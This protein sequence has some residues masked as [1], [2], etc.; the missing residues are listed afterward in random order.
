MVKAVAIELRR[1]RPFA[2]CPSH[3]GTTGDQMQRFKSSSESPKEGFFWGVL[4]GITTCLGKGS[5]RQLGQVCIACLQDTLNAGHGLIPF[6]YGAF[7]SC[8][9][10]RLLAPSISRAS[11]RRVSASLPGQRHHRNSKGN[12]PPTQTIST[13]WR[14]LLS[15]LCEGAGSC[16]FRTVRSALRPA[17]SMP[18]LLSRARVWRD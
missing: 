9:Q 14:C 17:A 12:S 7:V 1:T 10:T 13:S 15:R 11:H 6:L 2:N 8:T 3:D 18:I 16:A 5:R 4:G